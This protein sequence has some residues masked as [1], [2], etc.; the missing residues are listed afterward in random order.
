[1]LM[2]IQFGKIG[3]VIAPT[4]SHS[5]SGK[6]SARAVD[7]A[8]HMPAAK[9]MRTKL[10]KIKYEYFLISHLLFAAMTPAGIRRRIVNTVD[11]NKKID[12]IF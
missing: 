11:R 7:G 1:M 5:A 2:S 12:L 8:S 9:L 3:Q 10:M 6:S 4:T